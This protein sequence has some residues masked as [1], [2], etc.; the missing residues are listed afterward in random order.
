MLNDI[1][2]QTKIYSFPFFELPVLLYGSNM[3]GAKARLANSYIKG[4]L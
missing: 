4:K 1:I 3:A 2:F